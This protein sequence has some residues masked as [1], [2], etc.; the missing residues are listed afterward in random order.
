[1]DIDLGTDFWKAVFL[2]FVLSSVNI[3]SHVEV[4]CTAGF[5]C[6]NPGIQREC[7][8]GDLCEEGTTDA[9]TCPLGEK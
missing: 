6:I 9:K 8:D 4:N 5:E 2:S 1:M 3:G 7:D